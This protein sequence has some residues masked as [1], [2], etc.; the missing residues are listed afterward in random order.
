MVGSVWLDRWGPTGGD[1]N[2]GGGATVNSSD[3]CGSQ[4]RPTTPLPPWPRFE[5]DAPPRFIDLDYCN[6]TEHIDGGYRDVYCD[7]WDAH[8]NSLYPN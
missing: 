3:S 5:P 4:R 6:I 1:P 2:G 8:N 7:F